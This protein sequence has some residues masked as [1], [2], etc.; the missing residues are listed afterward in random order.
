MGTVISFSNQ[1]EGVG[2]TAACVNLAAR[3]AL[4]GKRVL[5]VD[6]DPAGHAAACL[7]VAEQPK[8][9]V[10]QVM[11]DDEEIE[12]AVL[13]TEI[14]GLFLLP[15]GAGLAG[16]EVELVY[17][18]HREKALKE[19]IGAVRGEY[20]A[21]LIDCPSSL[22]LLTIN[23]LAASDSVIVPVPCDEGESGL[24]RLMNTVSLVRLHLNK[25]LRVEGLL[26][27]L[28]DG[29]SSVAKQVAAEVR[30]YFPKKLYET[31][32]PRGVR[33]A[34]ASCEGRPEAVYD[35][36]SACGRAFGAFAEEF[37]KK[38]EGKGE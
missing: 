18:D 26:L 23:A 1:R 11:I 20:D 17:R 7:G 14:P 10:Y 24:D 12:G 31:V 6:I 19:A 15:P 35:P 32:I 8:R 3:L 37:M 13:P 4:A 28:Y 38:T 2:K 16:A 29:R 5:L 33:A 27:T 30:R 21:I 34:E 9:G 36:K 25:G 22:G